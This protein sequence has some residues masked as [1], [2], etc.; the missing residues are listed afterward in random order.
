MP[1]ELPMGFW[2]GSRRGWAIVAAVDDSGDCGGPFDCRLL[3]DIGDDR[4]WPPA[5]SQQ[6]RMSRLKDTHCDL[7]N[8]KLNAMSDNCL[9]FPAM[10]LQHCE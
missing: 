6:T 7:S 4:N 1:G 5:R 10:G 8:I 3:S 2:A 9:T